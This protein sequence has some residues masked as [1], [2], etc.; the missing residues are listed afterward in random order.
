[1]STAERL[2]RYVRIDT[3][4]D[5]KS[6][7]HPSTKKQFNLARL[8]VQE[9]K[10]LGLS[11]AHVDEHCYVYAH[12][13]SSVP[14]NVPAI[15]FVAHMDTAPDFS[16]KG[17]KPRII[18]NYDGG[19]IQ[20]NKT[21]VTRVKDFPK[22]AGL[23]GKTLMVTDGT[24]L[25]GADDKAGIAAIMGALEYY[26]THPEETHGPVSIAFTPD[27]EIGEGT[28]CFDYRKFGAAFAYTMDGESVSVYSD[29]TFNAEHAVVTV[30]GFSIH[31]GSA[32]GKMKNAILIASE[33]ISKLP[34]KDTPA[35]TE[36]REGF[37]HVDEI[38]GSV[39][40]A[41]MEIILRDFTQEKLREFEAVLNRNA[42][43]LNKKYGKGTITVEISET[44][45]NMNEVLRNYPR[46]SELASDAIRDL[47]YQPERIPTRGGTD[48]AVISFQGIPCPNL[49]CG[50]DNFHGPYE[51]CV[52]EEL[53]DAAVLIR[54][55]LAAAAE[56][57][58]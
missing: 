38:T 53:A 7:T 57:A 52:L 14:W 58:K 13:P 44:Y 8:L 47:G 45:R 42:R 36:G 6:G 31:P 26:H 49:G 55:I 20:L 21:M 28:R 37:L 12:L 27:E 41:R 2:G 18:E 1:M 56:E 30:Q 22:L 10:G 40:S 5:P 35:E 46:V 25:L 17:V 43:D 54:R 9:L 3:K 23:K 29:E 19:D 32:K 24:T 50:G 39:E 51:Y 4:S 11:D 16:G 48:G 34:K 15:G 33:F